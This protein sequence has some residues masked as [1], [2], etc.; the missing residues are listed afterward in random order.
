MISY[1]AVP[2]ANVVVAGSQVL[3]AAW[4]PTQHRGKPGGPKLWS[5]N[6][7]EELFHDENPFAMP[8]LTDEQI[9]KCMDWAVGTKGKAPNS[10]RRGLVFQ[11][12]RRLRQVAAYDDL[13]VA[14]GT[15]WVEPK[16]LRLHVRPLA[17]ADP[18]KVLIEITMRGMIFAPETFGLGYIRVK[19]LVIEHSGNGF[20]RPQQGAIST[21]RGHHW[22][23][24]DNTVRE[25]NAIGIDIGD[26]FDT[27]GP[28]LAEGGQH[29]VRGNT[30]SDCGIGGIEGKKIEQT[31]IE[32]NHVFRSGWQRAQFIWETGGIKV[33]CTLSCLLR[34]NIVHDMIDAPGIWMDYENRNSRCTQN[35]IFRTRSVNGGIFMEASQ[36]PNLVDRNIVWGANGNGIYQHD[37]DELLILHNLVGRS[38][39]AGVRMQICSGRVV[40]G[41]PTTAKRNKVQ[42]NILVDNGQPMAI[43]DPENDIDWNL[44]G[45][46]Q[47]S[48]DLAAWQSKHGWDKHSSVARVEGAFAAGT[49]E[50]TLSVNGDIPHCPRHPAVGFDFFNRAYVGDVC[51]G[52]FAVMP[53]AADKIF[54]GIAG[55]VPAATKTIGGH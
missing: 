22:I 16:G 47:K 42:G 23:I 31:L 27:I 1:E 20:P 41:R 40:G 15:Y 51:P 24:E 19:G 12:G 8:N 25:C 7:P 55:K 10:L 30:V 26:Q 29:V 36:M 48:F 17:D 34:R 53:A 33:H 11:G 18:N 52:P 43:S 45:A 9:D 50:L 3:P 6:L 46:G 35:V 38:T 39:D 5:T 2:G 32:E 49:L 44:I 28:P 21:M 13:A 54:L 4:V 37:C 14:S